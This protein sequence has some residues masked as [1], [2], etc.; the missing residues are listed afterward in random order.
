MSKIITIFVVIFYFTFAYGS[1]M[2]GIGTSNIYTN[3][4]K[5]D[6]SKATNDLVNKYGSVHKFRIEKGVKQ[7]AAFWHLEDG[8]NKEFTEFCLDNFLVDSLEYEQNFESLEKQ[9]E[10]VEGNFN[11][12]MLNLR[13]PIDVEVY[14][15]PTLLDYKFA[16]YNP[17]AHV[18]EDYFQNKIAFIILLN[19]PSYT[20]EEKNNL[21]KNWSRRDWAKAR[22]GDLFTSRVPAN[23]VQ[24]FTAIN[25]KADNYISNYNIMMGNII[26]KDNLISFPSDMK[27][28]SHWNLRDE[29]KANYPQKNGLQKQ[30]IIYKIML[31]II[32]QEIPNDIINNTDLSWEP[33]SNKVYKN[34][35]QIDVKAEPNTRYQLLLDNFKA[36]KE[37]DQFNPIYDT[38]IKRQFDQSVEI[39]YNDIEKMFIEFITSK[40]IKETA[41]IIKSKLKRELRP[42]DIWYDGFKDRSNIDIDA[43]TEQLKKKYPNASTFANDLPNILEKL[44]FTEKRAAWLSDKIAVDPSRGA[45]HASGSRSRNDKAH[46]R[47]RIGKDGMDYKGYNIAIHEF[48]H[49]VEQTF[50]LYNIDYYSLSGVPSNAFTEAFAFIFQARDLDI[51]GIK[52]KDPNSEYNNTLDNLWSAYEIMGVAL[53]DMYIWKWL[54]DN[55][56]ANSE[57]LKQNSVRIAKEVWNKYYANVLGEKNSPVLAIYSHIISYPLY[58]SA[59]PLGHLIEFQIEQHIKNRDFGKEVE[60]I[61]SLGRLTPLYW[62]S[63][64]VGAPLSIKPTLDAAQEAINKLKVQK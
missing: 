39:S 50:S 45:G 29:L 48:G 19:F 31:R 9:L 35:K 41:D 43:I 53:T 61:T 60:R 18:S 5:D 16:A 2:K 11:N 10:N 34:N 36:L 22:V 38:Y 12:M 46:L 23:I 6:I 62:M 49:N 64:A 28:I 13:F 58:L 3:I 57:Q 25:S 4:S 37:M 44:G 56:D 59:Y 20:L 24:K 32:N 40:Q 21:G 33:F 1:D 15:K 42:F 52:S 51:F 63:Q 7:V 17:S 26:D 30:E 27:L 54:Y 47:T 55:P 8:S 14:E